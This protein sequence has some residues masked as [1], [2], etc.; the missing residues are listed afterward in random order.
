MYD[1]YSMCD[2][3]QAL[4]AERLAE[5]EKRRVTH[6]AFVRTRAE[7]RLHRAVAVARRAG[8]D[9]D[10]VVRELADLMS[11]RTAN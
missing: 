10:V 1:M 8:L 5:A 11:D 3:A 7:A 6:R 2:T 9:Q 4:V